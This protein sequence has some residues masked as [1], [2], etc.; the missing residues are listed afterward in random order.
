MVFNE[1]DLHHRICDGA[2]HMPRQFHVAPSLFGFLDRPSCIRSQRLSRKFTACKYR[3]SQFSE[4]E[5]NMLTRTVRHTNTSLPTE[6][7]SLYR[8]FLRVNSAVVLHHSPSKTQLHRLWRPVFDEAAFKIHRLQHH[9]VCSSERTNI[10]QWLYTWHRRGEFPSSLIML[11]SEWCTEI[12]S[13]SYTF[14][15]RDRGG[16]KRTRP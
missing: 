2:S 7:R 11:S 5:S 6:F 1:H 8:L 15:T 13:G 10:V 12:F 16:I 3:F 9:D 14:A 4:A